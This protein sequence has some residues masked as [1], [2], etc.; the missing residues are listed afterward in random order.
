MVPRL[1]VPLTQRLLA[2]NW[3]LAIRGLAFTASRVAKSV[4]VSTPLRVWAAWAVVMPVAPLWSGAAAAVPLDPMRGRYGRRLPGT[5]PPPSR[6]RRAARGR[7]HEPRP[8]RGGGSFHAV[9]V[10]GPPRGPR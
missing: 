7:R 2:R 9:G 4:A 5:C 10:V 6:G 1:W 3:K 8:G